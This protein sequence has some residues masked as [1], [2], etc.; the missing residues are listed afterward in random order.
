MTSRRVVLLTL[1]LV[2]LLAAVTTVTVAGLRAHVGSPCVPAVPPVDPQATESAWCVAETLDDWKSR[3]VMGIGQQ[4]DVQEAARMRA[5][6]DALDPLHPA[7]VGFDFAELLNAQAHFDNDPVPYLS[8]LAHEGRVLAATWHADNPVTGGGFDDRS[9]TS[10]GELLDPSSDASARFWPQYDRVLTQALRFQDQGV[11]VIFKPFHEASGHWFWWGVPDPA[12][13]KRLF[14]QLQSRAY[15]RGVHN[16]LWGYAANPQR[17]DADADPVALLPVAVDIVG[18]DVYD[19]PGAQ[20]LT[21]TDY[22]TLDALAPRMAFTEVGP[23]DS[24]SGDWS[25]EVITDTLRRDGLYATYAMLWR[26]DPPPGNRYQ[27]SSLTGGLDWLASCPD[28]LCSLGG[29]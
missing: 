27:I 6:L 8:D 2:I 7:V 23:R 25:P 21:V 19:E 14:A 11:T 22:E 12:T 13:Y 16:L 29:P 18:I 28:G 20:A 4:L 10:V 17:F 24:T 1:G 26:D 15:A 9:W 3:D 5:P